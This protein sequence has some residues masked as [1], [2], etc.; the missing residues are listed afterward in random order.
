MPDW[1]EKPHARRL[2]GVAACLRQDRWSGRRRRGGGR[3]ENKD[4]NKVVELD[5]GEK[6]GEAMGGPYLSGNDNLAL[7]I[8]PS[9][10]VKSRT[11]ELDVSH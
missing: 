3:D 7:K 2:V 4:E 10:R 1:G 11:K 5:E 9:L 8:P 6:E